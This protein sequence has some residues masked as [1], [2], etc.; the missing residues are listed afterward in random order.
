VQLKLAASVLNAD[1]GYLADQVQQVEAAGVD[2]IHVDVMDGRFVPNISLGFVVVEA[3]RRSTQLPLDVHLMIEQPE[4]YLRDFANAGATGVTVHQEAVRHL[5][6]AIADM[7]ALGLRA[8]VAICPATPLVAVEEIC[9]DLD[10]L[11]V[12][13]I[14]PGFGGQELIPATI[15][16]VARARRLLDRHDSPAELEVDGGVKAYNV[17]DLVRAGADTLVV[18]TGV[19]RAPDGIAAGVAEIRRA[20]KDA[21]PFAPG[22]G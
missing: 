17:G 7:R 4:G 5:H 18:G 13:T 15:D 2:Y 22:R 14:N 16:K 11:L 19:F 20:I 10:L 9:A 6:K 21:R 12:M 1:F 3:I 8:G